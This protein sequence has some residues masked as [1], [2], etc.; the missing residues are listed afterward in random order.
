MIKC[1]LNFQ[2]KRT[3]IEKEFSTWLKEC[4][5]LHDKSIHFTHYVGQV[6][7]L[8][9]PKLKQTPWS[10]YKQVEWDGR[11]FKHGQMVSRQ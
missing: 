4:H 6:Q 7:R 10:A 3:G 1:M 5:E 8:D 9:L 11:V 2:E